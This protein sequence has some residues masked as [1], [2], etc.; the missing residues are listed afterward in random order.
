[1]RSKGLA[2]TTSQADNGGERVSRIVEVSM[3]VGESWSRRGKEGEPV[4][5]G[6]D[7]QAAEAVPFLDAERTDGEAPDVQA[8]RPPYGLR[9]L[10]EDDGADPLDGDVRPLFS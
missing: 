8:V 9:E 7:G 6:A 4:E 3:S 2:L 5:A 1:M 10:P